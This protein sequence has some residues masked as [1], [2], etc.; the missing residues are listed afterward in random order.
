MLHENMDN[1]LGMGQRGEEAA[2]GSLLQRWDE[3]GGLDLEKGWGGEDL[4]L[5]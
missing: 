4:Q 1:P 3:T 5:P 2:A